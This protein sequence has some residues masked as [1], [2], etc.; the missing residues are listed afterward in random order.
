MSRIPRVTSILLLVG[1]LASACNLPNANAPIPQNPGAI[2]TAAAQTVVAQLTQAAPVITRTPTGAV[3]P[4]PTAAIQP[5]GP[6]ATPALS[7]ASPPPPTATQPPPT[8][9]P[10]PPTAT[11]LPPTATPVPLPCNWAEFVKD[12]SV[13]DGSALPPGAGFTKTWRLK[14][15]GSCTWD[16]TY[17]LVFFSGDPLGGTS[18]PL[19]GEVRPGQSVNLSVDLV[20]PNQPGAYKGNWKLRAGSKRFG[21]GANADK[22]FFV[23][24]KV[25]EVVSGIVYNFADYYCSARWESGAGDLPCP[26]QGGDASGFVVH[27]DEP[28]LE[29]RHENESTLWTHPQM[30]KNGWIT[31]SFPAI[32]IKAGDRF[33]AAVGCLAGYKSC[34]VVFQLKYRVGASGPSIEPLGEWHEIYDGVITQVDLDLSPLAGKSVQFILTVLAN[35][36]GKNDAAFW[37]MPQ[38]FRP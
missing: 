9:T 14:N 25:A 38:I 12:V 26:G 29:S 35:G 27:L 17:S 20:T 33:R 1:L 4:Q 19:P 23:T 22:P 37:L 7:P 15:I 34:D 16:S 2:Y 30:V 8:T 32:P 6:T 18:V 31:G 13:P 21:I 28:S 10:L 36:D 24:I 11:P 3:Q 5:A